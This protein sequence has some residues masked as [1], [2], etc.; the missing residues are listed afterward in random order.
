M[1]TGRSSVWLS[2]SV[3]STKKTQGAF[4]KGHDITVQMCSWS[5]STNSLDSGA[6]NISLP[7]MISKVG[8][9]ADDVCG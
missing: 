6:D 8:R 9:M 2:L 7:T 5:N 1:V 4:K 3:V